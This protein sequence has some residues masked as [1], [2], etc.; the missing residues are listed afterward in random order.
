GAMLLA[1][2]VQAGDRVALLMGNRREHLDLILGCAWIGAIAVPINVAARGVQLHHILNN[3][4]ARVIAIESE[5]MEPLLPLPDLAA[6]TD[7]WTLGTPSG[8]LDGVRVRDLPRRPNRVPPAEVRPSDTAVILYT[9]G[10]TGA[11]KGVM[12]PQ[13][14]FFWWGY[15]VS[16]QFDLSEQD[17]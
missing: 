1:E 2:G 3:S 13:A 8:A 4:G 16:K 10:T 7:V 6:L 15:N 14:Q 11:A 17:V 5:L 9:S 12:C